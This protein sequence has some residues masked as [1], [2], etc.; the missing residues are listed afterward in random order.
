MVEPVR[1]TLSPEQGERL[2][3]LVDASRLG[4][5]SHSVGTFD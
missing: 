5:V 1:S 3:Q 2:E 4:P